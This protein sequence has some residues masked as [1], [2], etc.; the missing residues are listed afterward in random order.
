[1]PKP[2]RTHPAFYGLFILTAMVFVW[3][4]FAPRDR[5]V[6]LLDS[7]PVSIGILLVSIT[8]R[9][10]PLSFLL[11]G[12]LFLSATMMLIGAHYTFSSMPLFDAIRDAY[13]LSRNHYDRVGHFF[14][15]VIGA[16]VIRECLIRTTPLRSNIWL[17]MIPAVM[18]LGFSAGYELIEWIVSVSLHQVPEE[19][20]GLQ[21]DIWD[22]QEDMAMALVGA[23]V[24][25]LTLSKLHDK[26]VRS[27][28]S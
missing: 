24:S 14:Q 18:S 10:F 23:V 27:F 17:F 28:E 20:L 21:G 4:G 1:M 2:I 22:T 5:Y 12:L 13:G 7:I 8:H 26:Y 15:G 16:M 6:W 25:L 9:R 11:S 19:F 3:S